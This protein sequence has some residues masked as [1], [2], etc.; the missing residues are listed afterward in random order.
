MAIHTDDNHYL[1]TT[2]V[3]E[4]IQLGPPWSLFADRGSGVISP[5][6]GAVSRA[7]G[8]WTRLTDVVIRREYWPRHRSVIGKLRPITNLLTSCPALSLI[9]ISIGLGQGWLFTG[10][11]CR[12]TFCRI[13]LRCDVYTG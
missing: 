5:N 2:D 4:L 11:C 10:E 7:V 6:S 3:L 9:H 8:T 12:A 1:P 13:S